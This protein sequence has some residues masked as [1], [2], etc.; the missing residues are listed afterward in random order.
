VI[1]IIVAI[2]CSIDFVVRAKGSPIPFT[3]IK[4]L[5]VTGVYRYVRNPL[6]IAGSSVLIGE[7]LMF[8]SFGLLIY[9]IIMFA[10]FYLLALMEETVLEEQF[11]VKYKQ[12]RRS[13]PRWIPR[14]AP[15]EINETES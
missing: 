13:V 9:F 15:Y 12:Y 4:E 11:G 8:Q 10:Q 3:P 2:R 5:I 7:T 1:G 6:Y 14:L